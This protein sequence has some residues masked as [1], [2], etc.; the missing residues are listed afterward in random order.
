MKN[1]TIFILF[2]HF[3][4]GLK[5][6]KPFLFFNHHVILY[7][8]NSFSYVSVN[9]DLLVFEYKIQRFLLKLFDICMPICNIT[10]YYLLVTNIFK[11]FKINVCFVLSCF[12]TRTKNTVCVLSFK[13]Y[14]TIKEHI[15]VN[16]FSKNIP[17]N[18]TQ[19]KE[20]SQIINDSYSKTHFAITHYKHCSNVRAHPLNI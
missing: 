6:Y 10:W 19:R 15:L 20:A 18:F 4:I 17:Y 16:F 12:W 5:V 8:L 13:C 2:Y 14:K 7:T 9:L 1:I 11:I 3:Y